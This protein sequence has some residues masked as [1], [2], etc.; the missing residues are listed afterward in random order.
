M[1]GTEAVAWTLEEMYFGL[2]EFS[3]YRTYGDRVQYRVEKGLR[4]TQRLDVTSQYTAGTDEI[5]EFIATHI[6]CEFV[7]ARGYTANNG[8]FV[9]PSLWIVG[10]IELT[11][12]EELQGYRRAKE[13]NWKKPD[14]L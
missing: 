2:M 3:T 11:S 9:A 8:E 1:A 13:V 14:E 6:D 4:L 7:V 10:W 12:E 5:A